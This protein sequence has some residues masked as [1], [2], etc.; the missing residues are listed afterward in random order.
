M[1]ALGLWW[2]RGRGDAPAG[3]AAIVA[4]A[5]QPAQLAPQL[6]APPPPVRQIAPA[7]VAKA[8]A[9]ANGKLV[10][11]QGEVDVPLTLDAKLQKDVQALLDQTRVPYGAIVL[12]DPKTGAI[13]AMA[14]H[15]EAGDPVAAIGG[16]GQPD[17]PAASVFKV[18]TAAALLQAGQTPDT[19]VCFHGGKHGIDASHVHASPADRQCQ[20][21]TEAL[22]HSSNAAFARLALDHLKPGDMRAMAEK[23]GWGTPLL[24]DLAL[25]ASSIDE[26]KTELDRARCAPGFAGS[27]LSPLHGAFLAATV[28]NRGLAM[29]PHLLQG[30]NRAP[31]PMGQLLSP[32]VADGLAAMMTQ[33]VAVGTGRHAFSVRP[34]SLRGMAIA[35]K[36]GS[37]SNNDPQNYRHFSFCS[38]RPAAGRGGGGGGQR[39]AMAGER[40]DSGA[41]RPGAGAGSRARDGKRPDKLAAGA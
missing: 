16:L 13:L 22:A 11:R 28:A 37:L 25:V 8:T 21:L 19:R 41:R 2:L 24:G 26:G 12:M 27:T 32:E 35:G 40:R 34:R 15:R 30:Q 9:S 36:T 17:M 1:I 20:T 5:N 6:P 7:D 31:E 38:G 33:T 4:A 10:L 3:S 39:P 18:V 23:L 29:R 14:E